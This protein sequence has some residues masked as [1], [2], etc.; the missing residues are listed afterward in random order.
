MCHLL[1]REL[2]AAVDQ[3]VHGQGARP[4]SLEVQGELLEMLCTGAIRV[5]IDSE[6]WVMA[7]NV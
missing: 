6:S 1:G 5:Q 4:A 7:A 2:N 3:V